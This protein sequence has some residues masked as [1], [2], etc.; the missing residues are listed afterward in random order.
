MSFTLHL[1]EAIIINIWRS[2]YYAKKSFAATL[3]LSFLL[4]SLE[5]LILPFAFLFDVWAIKYNLEGINIVKNDF[6]SM[7]GIADKNRPSQYRNSLSP[8]KLTP[9]LKVKRS[10]SF[11]LL[12]KE[13]VAQITEIKKVEQKHQVHLAMTLHILESVALFTK[14]AMK[15]IEQNPQTKLLS[16]VMIHFQLLALSSSAYIDF[17]AQQ[18]HKRGVGIT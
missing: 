2:F 1:L 9:L 14:N 10:D 13:L 12:Y 5:I 8:S 16:Q 17:F 7:Q 11:V 18:F 4:I 6:V 15:Y 3:P